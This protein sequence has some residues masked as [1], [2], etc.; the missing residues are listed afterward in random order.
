MGIV[1]L[2]RT[3]LTSM[4]SVNKQESIELKFLVFDS[5]LSLA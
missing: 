2:V 5:L 1:R 4:P 3:A